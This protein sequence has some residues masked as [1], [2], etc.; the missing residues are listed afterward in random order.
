MADEAPLS[1][2]RLS[3]WLD[4][5]TRLLDANGTSEVPCGSCTACCRSAQF[6]H[7]DADEAD[8]LSRIPAALLFPAPGKPEGHKILPFDQDGRCPMLGNAGCRIYEHR[9]RTCRTYDCRVFAA[10][11][12]VP[13]QPLIADRV[14]RWQFE[15]LD[16]DDRR[17]AER[18][19]AGALVAEGPGGT[20]RALSIV[21]A[22]RDGGRGTEDERQQHLG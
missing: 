11:D 7:I 13:E 5:F 19:R 15:V 14:R 3:E 9:P 2:G 21:L 10:A 22:A 8:T 1:A 12:V 18:L 6:V 17:A 20:R 4:G 16:T